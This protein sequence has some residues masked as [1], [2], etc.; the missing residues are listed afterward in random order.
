MVGDVAEWRA[1][2]FDDLQKLRMLAMDKLG[3]QLNGHDEEVVVGV[4]SSANALAGFE[5]DYL[6]ARR[7][8]IARRSQARGARADY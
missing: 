5:Q 6:D 2:R 7:A 3:A 8:A 4:D 1:C